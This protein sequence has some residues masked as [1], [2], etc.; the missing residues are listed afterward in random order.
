MHACNTKHSVYLTAREKTSELRERAEQAAADQSPIVVWE[1][2]RSIRRL[3]VTACAALPAT[4]KRSSSEESCV[5]SAAELSD[6]QHHIGEF[7][8][9]VSLPLSYDPFST[10]T[11]P[12]VYVL[13]SREP[14]MCGEP[15]LFSLISTSARLCH[16]MHAA[17]RRQYPD[18]IVVSARSEAAAADDLEATLRFVAEKAIPF[19]DS[20]YRTQPYSSGRALCGHGA[21]GSLVARTV[22]DERVGALFESYLV[23]APTALPEADL[24]V[25]RAAGGCAADTTTPDVYVCAV[26]EGC[27]RAAASDFA[28]ALRERA[29]GN[30]GGGKEQSVV[31]VDP[32]TG[33][34][35]LRSLQPSATKATVRLDWIDVDREV[36]A[37]DMGRG[38]EL[39]C[40]FAIRAVSWL[41]DLLERK[42]LDTLGAL[43]PWSEFR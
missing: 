24:W 8:V 13:D 18:L 22:L 38:L 39:A 6:E 5:H 15:S 34:Q 43:V 23:G 41:G 12:V 27:D 4:S 19:V 26:G 11:H 31:Q 16:Q 42:R 36:P 9:H 32:H 21:G 29:A 40:P 20:E 17:S 35:R 30:A 1:M 14:V 25:G 10:R 7:S 33:E 2:L 3:S 37:L 28:R